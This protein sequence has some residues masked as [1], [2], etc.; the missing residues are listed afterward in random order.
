MTYETGGINEANAEFWNELCGSGLAKF[1]GITDSSAQSLNK[2]DDWYFDYYPYLVKHIPVRNLVGKTVL[3]VGLGYG[4]VSQLLA[5]AG[6]RYY[7]LDIAHGPV[8]MVCHRLRQTGLSGEVHQGS[9][10]NCPFQDAQFDYVVAIGC[11]HHTGNLARAIDQTQRILKPGGCATIMVYNV[12]S[13]R[14]WLY[15]PGSTLSYFLW[16]K[17]GIGQPREVSM[18]ERAA[19]DKNVDDSVAP[20]TVFVS[21]AHLRRMTATWG[22]FRATRENIGAESILSKIPRST[23]LKILGP[24]VGLDLYCQLKK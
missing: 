11:Y 15:W 17:F 24:W 9:I 16:D 3:E 22:G 12:Y 19:Y 21:I 13:Y 23:L 7:G 8:E 14:R 10:L 1:L 18:G 6:T 5:Q 2:F 4:T 20:E